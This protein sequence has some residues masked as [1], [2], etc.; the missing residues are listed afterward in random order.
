MKSNPYISAQRLQV[1]Q[2]PHY[3]TMSSLKTANKRNIIAIT[4]KKTNRGNGRKKTFF[5]KK[6][7]GLHDLT[8]QK[9]L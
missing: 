3:K 6:E 2:A 1:G 4:T 9:V 7:N 8:E 5:K